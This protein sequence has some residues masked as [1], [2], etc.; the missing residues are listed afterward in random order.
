[1]KPGFI[2]NAVQNLSQ[3][4]YRAEEERFELVAEG[5]F[6]DAAYFLCL[7]QSLGGDAAATVFLLSDLVDATEILGPRGYRAAQLEAGIRAGRLYLGAYACG[8]G[9][10]GLTFYDDE[11]K[12]LFQTTMEP[13]LVVALGHPSRGRRLL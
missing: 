12:K 8:F 2:V 6:R 11:V 13:M 5:D 4:A 3:G 1:M 9:A 10:T 7:E